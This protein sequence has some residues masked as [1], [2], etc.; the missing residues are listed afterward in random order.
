MDQTEILALKDFGEPVFGMT[1]ISLS[2]RFTVTV[3][4]VLHFID[5][6]KMYVG[7]PS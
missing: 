3:V 7:C 1:L 5:G 6:V 2:S 4:K